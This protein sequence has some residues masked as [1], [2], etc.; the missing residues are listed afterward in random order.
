[1]Y[2][3][4]N[5]Y[6]SA[7]R[8]FTLKYRAVEF[9]F[10]IFF[11]N[12]I[13]FIN[14]FICPQGLYS[15]DIFLFHRLHFCTS[16]HRS[17]WFNASHRHLLSDVHCPRVDLLRWIIKSGRADEESIWFVPIYHVLRNYYYLLSDILKKFFRWR[18]RR[19]WSQLSSQSSFQGYF[20]KF[21]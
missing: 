18:R 16:V 19:L 17:K 12:W 4:L 2:F 1:M 15:F 20:F 6:R 21:I 7:F 5:K 8:C 10:Q 14:F 11:F 3:Y 13:E 9:G